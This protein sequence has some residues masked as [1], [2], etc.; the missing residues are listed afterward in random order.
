M[1]TKDERLSTGPRLLCAQA[2]RAEGI[3]ANGFVMRAAAA[4]GAHGEAA[5]R[6]APL[7]RLE[8]CALQQRE[9]DEH[10]AKERIKVRDRAYCRSYPMK[11]YSR[12]LPSANA[13]IDGECVKESF[14]L[15]QGGPICASSK[16]T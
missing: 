13:G 10:L 11:T 9:L 6:L 12:G 8:G 16:M 7:R 1:L 15:K 5:E 2:V 4:G 3:Y 14:A